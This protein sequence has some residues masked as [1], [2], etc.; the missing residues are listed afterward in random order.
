MKR[1]VLIKC[2]LFFVAGWR[3]SMKRIIFITGLLFFIAGCE[4]MTPEQREAWI[5]SLNQYEQQQQ[6]QP[7][8]QLR[9]LYPPTYWQEKLAEQEYWKDYYRRRGII[10]PW[11]FP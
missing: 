4:T 8:Y 3:K 2:L 10:T 7:L 6:Q 1:V 11:Q 9:P 5:D